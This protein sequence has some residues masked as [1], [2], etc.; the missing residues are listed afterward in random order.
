[1]TSNQG[2]N[3]SGISIELSEPHDVK[4]VV[5]GNQVK[6]GISTR[7]FTVQDVERKMRE[8]NIWI[9]QSGA[10]DVMNEED[11]QIRQRIER[12]REGRYYSRDDYI[13]IRELATS[14]LVLK[15]P[16]V[17]AEGAELNWAI[18]GRELKNES[19]A[20][21]CLNYDGNSNNVTSFDIRR[22]GYEQLKNIDEDGTRTYLEGDTVDFFLARM[23]EEHEEDVFVPE[24][25]MNVWFDGRT[26]PHRKEDF[27]AYVLKCREDFEKPLILIPEL[28]RGHWTMTA[29]VNFYGNAGDTPMM[30]LHFNSYPHESPESF[31]KG[32]RLVDGL[33]GV[34][35][36]P[37]SY[38][39]QHPAWEWHRVYSHYTKLEDGWP[40]QRKTDCG[41]F[42]CMFAHRVIKHFAEIKNLRPSK[43]ENATELVD[44][45]QQHQDD[46]F[47]R[48]PHEEVTE[49]MRVLRL[50]W[51]ASIAA[52]QRMDTRT[53]TMKYTAGDEAAAPLDAGVRNYIIGE[54]DRLSREGSHDEAN[55]KRNLFGLNTDDDDGENTNV[56]GGGDELLTVEESERSDDDEAIAEANAGKKPCGGDDESYYTRYEREYF[57]GDKRRQA[58][59]CCTRKKRRCYD[60]QP[61]P[62][63]GTKYQAGGLICKA[64]RKDR[65]MNNGPCHFRR[66]LKKGRRPKNR[67]TCCGRASEENQAN[68]TLGSGE[69]ALV[70]DD[71][72]LINEATTPILDPDP[73]A[74]S[75]SPSAAV[76]ARV[77]PNDD[78][79]RVGVVI[80]QDQRP[81]VRRN[82]PL[83][84]PI[85][86]RAIEGVRIGT[87]GINHNGTGGNDN[88]NNRNYFGNNRNNFPNNPHNFGTQ[89]VVPTHGEVHYNYHYYQG[90]GPVYNKAANPIYTNGGTHLN[91]GGGQIYNN[92][93]QVGDRSGSNRSRSNRSGSNRHRSGSNRSGS[94]STESQRQYDS[95]NSTISS[96]G[97]A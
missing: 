40:S 86:R 16:V 10:I 77:T 80:A 64:C 42:A 90:S 7:P 52:L 66:A 31:E 19:D 33:L 39:K 14:E 58:C 46:F 51:A 74:P 91:S 44:Y 61:Y 87:N 12:N 25:K 32:K 6:L 72:G 36:G 47:L 88:N 89:G 24:Y 3:I 92:V 43:P 85:K 70:D 18:F 65:K 9:G 11:I 21:D 34:L 71:A 94:N 17:A 35:K 75:F 15:Y 57:D 69:D 13:N 78:A 20:F 8:S 49:S 82:G 22:T 60:L 59:D 81:L 27:V 84:R 30:M 67:N 37:H 2:D 54:I 23:K 73:P 95:D 28:D 4:V 93:R 26:D 48:K 5:D 83:F 41:V 97:N 53:Y 63:F 1:M 45:F 50:S 38:R 55:F 79:T 68:A 76:P 96:N 56:R 29:L 62:G